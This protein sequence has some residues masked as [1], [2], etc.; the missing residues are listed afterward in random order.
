[1]AKSVAS[2]MSSTLENEGRLVAECAGGAVD[3]DGTGSEAVTSPLMVSEPESV[4]ASDASSGRTHVVL[5][6][7]G[8]T[9]VGGL[10]GEAACSVVSQELSP[11]RVGDSRDD[12][13]VKYAAIMLTWVLWTSPRRGRDTP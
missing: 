2:S 11:R 1:M 3:P 9:L 4:L 10:V 12:V 6:L 8:L 13:D 7:Y 5:A